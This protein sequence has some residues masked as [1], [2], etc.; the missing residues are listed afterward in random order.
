MLVKKIFPI[1]VISKAN[2]IAVLW[3]Q[4]AA[5]RSLSCLCA[6][7]ILL[8]VHVVPGMEPVVVCRTAT[9]ILILSLSPSV[10]IF[11]NNLEENY[12]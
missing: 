1:T 7:G 6:Q 3:L 8:E 4:L 2:F 10:A 11:I 12:C 5:L 9:L